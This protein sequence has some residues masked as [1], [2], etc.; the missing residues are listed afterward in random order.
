ME[1]QYTQVGIASI[2]AVIDGFMFAKNVDEKEKLQA[3][4]MEVL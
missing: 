1:C 4:K 2:R 3:I